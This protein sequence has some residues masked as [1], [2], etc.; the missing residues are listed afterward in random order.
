MDEGKVQRFG[1]VCAYLFPHDY[2]TF[3][4]ESRSQI[5]SEIQSTSSGPS[6]QVGVGLSIFFDTEWGPKRRGK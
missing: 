5:G 2:Y 1:L 6:S 3:V 4:V